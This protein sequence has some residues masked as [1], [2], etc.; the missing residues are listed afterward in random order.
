MTSVLDGVEFQSVEWKNTQEAEIPVHGTGTVRQTD[1]NI[2]NWSC[3][4]CNGQFMVNSGDSIK[5]VNWKVQSKL[6]SQVLRCSFGTAVHNMNRCVRMHAKKNRW[7]FVT[8]R[9]LLLCKSQVR[10][11]CKGL[12]LLFQ[13]R[14]SLPC[15]HIRLFQ[16]NWSAAA[17]LSY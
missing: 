16:K 13:E 14:T 4:T 6:C 5:R 10:I 2:V 1:R 12:H 17:F 11:D 9:L 15:E 3:E 8:D 7:C